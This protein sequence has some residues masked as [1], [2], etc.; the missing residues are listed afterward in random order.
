MFSRIVENDLAIQQH[1]DYPKESTTIFFTNSEIF[2]SPLRQPPRDASVFLDRL[3]HYF[4]AE[5]LSRRTVLQA[6]AGGVPRPEVNGED[7]ENT[8]SERTGVLEV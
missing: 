2:R 7:F 4:M 1:E 6:L 8:G 5:E 3:F